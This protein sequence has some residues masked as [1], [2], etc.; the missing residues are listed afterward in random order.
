MNCFD[1]SSH[2]TTVDLALG[3]RFPQRRGDISLE[4]ANLF[5]KSFRFQDIGLEGSR[6][7]SERS[8]RLRLSVDL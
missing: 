5:D 8:C 3:Y 7:V 4:C 1:A 6:Y 2:F